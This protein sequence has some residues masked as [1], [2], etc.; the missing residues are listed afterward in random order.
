MCSV[1]IPTT[2]YLHMIHAPQIKRRWWNLS[3]FQCRVPR[4]INQKSKIR[5]IEYIS[6]TWYRCTLVIDSLLYS[7]E[8]LTFSEKLHT[9]T[10]V[11]DPHALHLICKPQNPDTVKRYGVGCSFSLRTQWREHGVKQNTPFICPPH[12]TSLGAFRFSPYFWLFVW[13][14]RSWQS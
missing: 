10:L 3:S 1:F 6:G 13:G 9:G 2:R 4:P 14:C 7:T 12:L 11:Q 8:F 5:S